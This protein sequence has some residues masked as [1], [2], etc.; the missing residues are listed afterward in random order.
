MK[1][2][3]TGVSGFVGSTLST[4]LSQNTDYNLVGILRSHQSTTIPCEIITNY[5]SSKDLLS[6]LKGVD[7]VVHLAARVHQIKD[8]SSDPLSAFRKVNV[9][10]TIQL[11]KLAINAGVKR[12]IFISSIKVNGD[13]TI[14]NE[15]FSP[16]LYSSK[17]QIFLNNWKLNDKINELDPYAVSKFEAEKSLINLCHDSNMEFVIIRPPL[18]YGQGVK[19]NFESLLK[20]A[21][22]NFPLPLSSVK[23]K[24]SFLYVKNLVHFISVC[25]NHPNAANQIFLVSDDSD[26]STTELYSTLVSSFGY[27]AKLIKCPKFILKFLFF[28]FGKYGT[29][30]RLCESLQ[31]DISKT[32]NLL[33]WSPPFSVQ[34]GLDETVKHWLKCN[35][36]SN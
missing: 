2:L 12:F 36:L 21:F 8:K 1:I 27:K 19:G 28:V 31:I 23:N 4:Y 22:K 18:V 5:T 10:N 30:S 17:H 3:I 29:Y 20:I 24:R 26:L 14:K 7:V 11:A 13:S 6:S 35:E 15:S 16:T 32:K 25:V 33:N 34:K 9:E